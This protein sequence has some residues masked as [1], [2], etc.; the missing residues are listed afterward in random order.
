MAIKANYAVLFWV[1]RLTDAFFIKPSCIY[2]T[3][4]V[5]RFPREVYLE[6]LGKISS[7]EMLYKIFLNITKVCTEKGLVFFL[8]ERLSKKAQVKITI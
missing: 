2:F 8:K 5:R 4:L 6:S 1:L 7:Y 3:S